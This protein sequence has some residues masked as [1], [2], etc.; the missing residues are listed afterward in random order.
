MLKCD[1]L[2]GNE[3]AVNDGDRMS[4]SYEDLVDLHFIVPT[5]NHPLINHLLTKDHE[6]P[7]NRLHARHSHCLL[8]TLFSMAPVVDCLFTNMP[9]KAA[10]NDDIVMG[11]H[12]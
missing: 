9:I 2:I 8:Q 6:C 11:R 7:Q 3:F 10:L 4:G 5:I 1:S 12:V